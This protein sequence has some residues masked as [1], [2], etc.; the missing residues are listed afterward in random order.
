VE[1]SANFEKTGSNYSGI[2]IFT[3][4]TAVKAIV[5]LFKS[6]INCLPI[7]AVSKGLLRPGFYKFRKKKMRLNAKPQEPLFGAAI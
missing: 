5:I 1:N 6:K 4:N 3:Q 7:Y 2:T